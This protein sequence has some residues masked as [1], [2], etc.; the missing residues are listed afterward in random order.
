MNASD[1]GV[2]EATASSNSSEGVAGL[3]QW[4]G[5]GFVV[6]PRKPLAVVPERNL[7]TCAVGRA[8]AQQSSGRVEDPEEMPARPRDAS[9]DGRGG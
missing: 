9:A 4:K 5:A 3:S 7:Q 8:R 1:S 6:Q 2:R